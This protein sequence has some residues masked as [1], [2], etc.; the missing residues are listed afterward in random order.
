M[1]CS[2]SCKMQMRMAQMKLFPDG[3]RG[4]SGMR[5]SADQH[6]LDVCVFCLERL[7]INMSECVCLDEPHQNNEPITYTRIQIREMSVICIELF[8]KL[9]RRIHGS[10]ER[11]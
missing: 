2:R 6:T 1:R 4:N 9:R 8:C 3:S 5:K 10:R 11:V 7:H